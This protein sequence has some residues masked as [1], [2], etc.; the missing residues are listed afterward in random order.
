[1]KLWTRGRPSLEYCI[2]VEKGNLSA[3]ST[4]T[5]F[6][7]LKSPTSTSLRPFEK[8]TSDARYS[9]LNLIKKK[10][11]GFY[12]NKKKKKEKHFR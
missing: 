12:P 8:E 10:R 11:R 2:A 4:S 1:M 6:E 9:T 3:L 5:T 7:A